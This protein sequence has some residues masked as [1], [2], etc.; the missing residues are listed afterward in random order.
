M[1][2][3]IAPAL[4]ALAIVIIAAGGVMAANDYCTRQ[5]DGTVV[6]RQ[7][8]APAWDRTPVCVEQPATTCPPGTTVYRTVD[9]WDAMCG[10]FCQ[11]GQIP[12]GWPYGWSAPYWLRPDSNF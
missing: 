7:C 12:V 2:K 10:A 11:S 8:P 4:T 1:R 5:P 9:P 6:C 3:L